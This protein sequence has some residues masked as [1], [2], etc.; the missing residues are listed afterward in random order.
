MAALND[1]ANSGTLTADELA[2][3]NAQ[4]SGH[5][6][7]DAHGALRQPMAAEPCTD[8]GAAAAPRKRRRWHLVVAIPAYC[9]LLVA[10]L[11]AGWFLELIPS[12][13][14]AR[15]L[16]LAVGAPMAFIVAVALLA[17]WLV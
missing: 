7:I 9:A 13:D 1:T 15:V 17:R 3:H 11:C 14:T 5:W 8:I 4:R 2:D 6:I 10:F 12:R 16:A